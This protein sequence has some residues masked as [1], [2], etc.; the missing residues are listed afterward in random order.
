M[1][2]RVKV[3]SKRNGQTMRMA[4]ATANSLVK[5]GF[6]EILGDAEPNKPR[7]AAKAASAKVEG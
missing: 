1:A 6:V 7:K 3:K 4:T 5:R 2:Q